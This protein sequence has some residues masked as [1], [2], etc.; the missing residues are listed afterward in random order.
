MSSV[1]REATQRLIN[2]E[3]PLPHPVDIKQDMIVVES[4]TVFVSPKS[5]VIPP[6]SEFGLEIIYRP[7]LAKE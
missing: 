5:F 3:N 1:V 7:L 4:D 2:I 6:K